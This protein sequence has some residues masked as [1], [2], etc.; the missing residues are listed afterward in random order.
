MTIKKYIL[1]TLILIL[2]ITSIVAQDLPERPA[3][4]RLVVDFSGILS[5]SERG[6]LENKLVNFNDTTSN[7]ILVLVTNDLMGHDISD[8][9]DRIGDKWGVGQKDF[10]NGIVVVL[11]PKTRNSRGDVWISIGYGLDGVIPDITAGKIIDN[12][13]IPYFKQ[14]DYYGGLDAATTVLMELAAGEYSS[15][16]YASKNKGAVWSILPFIILIIIITLINRQSRRS[17]TIGGRSSMSPW[18]AFWIGS[19]MGGASRGGGWG[20]GS[21]G[22]FGGGGGGFGGFGGGGFGGGGAGGSW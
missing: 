6:A 8:F 22:G 1:S 10:D 19:M 17:R 12:E 20:G 15:D 9:A 21:G 5:S 4:P 2:G 3:P 16:E 14:N 18:T 7:Q 11:K 13:M